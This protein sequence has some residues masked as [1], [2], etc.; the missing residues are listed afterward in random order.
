[1]KQFF[2]DIARLWFFTFMWISAA[3]FHL[4]N[5]L[6]VSFTSAQKFPSNY[7]DMVINFLTTTAPELALNQLAPKYYDLETDASSELVY[8][9]IGA[10]GELPDEVIKNKQ[11]FKQIILCEGEPNEAKRLEGLGFDVIPNFIGKA[12]ERVFYDVIKNPGASGLFKPGK[13][14]EL[15]FLALYGGVNY[16]I[17]H[18]NFKEAKVKVKDAADAISH[19]NL[20]KI[21]LLKID[22]Q[23]A[24]KEILESIFIGI[25]KKRLPR[26]L[27][28]N[29]E[30]MYTPYY[31]GVESGFKL[32]SF[33][34][35]QGYLVA[36]LSDNHF[37]N[38][39]PIWSDCLLIPD[40]N[41]T[42]NQA[43][44]VENFESFQTLLCM[45]N[46]TPLFNFIQ[47][48]FK[49]RQLI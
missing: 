40:W 47:N 43:F 38:G 30:V 5:R 25:N 35:D 21:D 44:L 37:R 36:E 13:Y 19:F 7:R 10:R 31:H 48:S 42:K 22:T 4:I 49:L 16:S 18:Q 17:E 1:M 34:I 8:V 41:K 12:S 39:L 20:N 28:I 3:P 24:E 6:L 33:M 23:G 27:M 32:L 2:L 14:G 26:P 15:D 11:L 29:L 45:H 9:D 46:K